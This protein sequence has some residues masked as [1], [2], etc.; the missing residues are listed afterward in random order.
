MSRICTQ[1]GR[2]LLL[3]LYKLILFLSLVD[4]TTCYFTR[5][6]WKNT[7]ET[8]ILREKKLYLQTH[9]HKSVSFKYFQ[10]LLNYYECRIPK[11]CKHRG[12]NKLPLSWNWPFNLTIRRQH[13]YLIKTERRYGFLFF[14]NN[15]NRFGQIKTHSIFVDTIVD[16][17]R[18]KNRTTK[19]SLLFPKYTTYEHILN[20][21]LPH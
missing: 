16:T 18:M 10:L 21:F 2:M 20:A 1:S 5:Y 9:Y 19:H 13:I 7:N 4:S 6:P 8:M 12:Q 15:T 17:I 11:K 3:T 14:V